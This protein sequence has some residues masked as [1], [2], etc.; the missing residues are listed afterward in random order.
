MPPVNGGE[1][2]VEGTP[3]DVAAE[4]KSATGQYLK[5]ML[6]RSTRSPAQAGAQSDKK[7]RRKAASADADQPQFRA[8]PGNSGKFRAIP[9]NSGANSG[10]TTKFRG[11][12]TN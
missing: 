7:T 2:V 6:E 9:A 4:P 8:I 12:N 5:P 10:D 11:H 1:I 3:E